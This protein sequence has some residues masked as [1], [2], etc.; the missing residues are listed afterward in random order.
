MSKINFYIQIDRIKIPLLLYILFQLSSAVFSQEV[1]LN[2]QLGH[3]Y[4]IRMFEFSNDDQY[5]LSCDENNTMI[6]WEIE[7]GV[8]FSRFSNDNIITY[9]KFSSKNNEVISSDIIGD[10]KRWDVESG[11]LIKMFRLNHIIYD[12]I[13]LNNKSE[14]LIASNKLIKLN[15]ETGKTKI[16]DNQ[17]VY[18]ILK[19]EDHYLLFYPDGSIKE[20]SESGKIQNS[21]YHLENI[22]EG[23]IE[24]LES[25]SQDYSVQ[26]SPTTITQNNLREKTMEFI[27]KINRMKLISLAGNEYI[28][29]GVNNKLTFYSLKKKKT[30]YNI[31]SYYLDVDFKAI[32]S[33]V[34]YEKVVI[35]TNDDRVLVYKLGRKNPSKIFNDHLNDITD[36]KFSQ[37]E[38]IF[39]TVS[40]DRSI[41]IWDSKKLLPLKRLYSKVFPISCMDID[42]SKSKL[43][44]GND[45]GIIKTINYKDLTK[46]TKYVKLHNQKVT[47]LEYIPHLKQTISIGVDNQIIS[48]NDT[49]NQI[50]KFKFWAPILKGKLFY[51]KKNKPSRYKYAKYKI[52]YK[53]CINLKTMQ[54]LVGGNTAFNYGKSKV[55][56]YSLRNHKLLKTYKLKK[57]PLFDITYF[58]NDINFI[59]IIDNQLFTP[60]NIGKL[61]IYDKS[62]NFSAIKF[63]DKNNILLGGN[64]FLIKKNLKNDQERKID[65]PSMVNSI[66]ADKSGLIG[67]SSGNDII[68][69]NNDFRKDK[70]KILSTHNDIVSD[71][72][73]IDNNSK[74]ISTS[75]DGLIKIWDLE[76]AEDIVSI[77][78]VDKSK[79]VTFTKDG[80]YMVNKGA[81]DGISFKKGMKIFPAEQFDLKFNRPDI[82]L[83]RLGYSSKELL[84]AYYKAYKKRLK[85]LGIKEEDLGADFHIPSTSIENSYDVPTVYQDKIALQLS[86]TDSKYKLNR[87]MIWVNDV[88]IYGISGK[89]I[90]KLNTHSF[91][92]EE[93]IL[94]S[95][96]A[97][98]IQVSC[99]NEKG[100]E[101]YKE[102]LELTYEPSVEE[103]PN[104]HIIA[105]SV[106]LYKQKQWNLNYA[107]KDGRDI[108]NQYLS[109]KKKWAD[110]KVD[111]LFNYKATRENILALKSK[112][113]NTNINDKVILYVSGHG[114]LDDN[115][116]F[117]FATHDIDFYKPSERGVSYE[118][119]EWLLDSIPARRKLFLMDAC[120][121]GEVDKEELIA[122]NAEKEKGKKSGVKKYSYK[123]GILQNEEYKSLG[124]QNSFEL[125]QELFSNLNR[126]SGAVV[127]SAA[128]GDS[129]AMESDEWENGVFTYSI[130]N[131]LKSGDADS[132]KDGEITV[133]ELRDYVS[134]SV[135]EL[136]NGLQKPTMRQENIEFDFRVW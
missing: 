31:M 103:M 131:G 82:V 78:S 97:N 126:G 116:D 26:Q 105:L 43:I 123:A 81:I 113:L 37:S 17:L 28:I 51:K 21:N 88:P 54:Y 64:K 5:I 44:Y 133:S 101:S 11:K 45:I 50:V 100:A 129:Y 121:S 13:I 108:V 36:I 24:Y 95:K 111:T 134:K 9:C 118:E 56:V 2:I 70:I 40:K 127:I 87:Y 106:S 23:I 19:Q 85:R 86:F 69:I 6:V 12:F 96:G 55:R 128:A 15:L 61:N 47:D 58:P 91:S 84:E 48:S 59:T 32:A 3:M 130:L 75:Y 49:N 136:T 98:K 10:I 18:K 83:E 115:F 71:I 34:K 53:I 93:T 7:S 8:D 16:I 33:S 132:N 94:L 67:V 76:T 4:G 90:H 66:I 114:L 104:L 72:R 124:L 30:K 107:V 125:M 42:T 35:G 1:E 68:V 57:S 41:I 74:L 112:L 63:L 22:N 46:N 119:L 52:P 80:Y 27:D 92:I 135:Q 39:A 20:L 29:Y 14:I 99:L 79:L 102:T 89:N 60:N 110:I 109:Q 122:Y 25:Y 117:Y 38:N 77:A 73:F 65:M 62:K 120:H